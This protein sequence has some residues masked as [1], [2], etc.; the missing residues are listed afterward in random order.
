MELKKET[1]A[2][3][4]RVAKRNGVALVGAPWN[5]T[6]EDVTDIIDK[7]G[8]RVAANLNGKR[9]RVTGSPSHLLREKAEGGNSHLRMGKNDA[10]FSYGR[11]WLIRGEH[12]DG[13]NNTVI[14]LA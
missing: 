6:L 7:Q 4:A 2:E 1:K 11:F 3:F 13:S 10:V 8:D 9:D 14:Y 5:K 12:E